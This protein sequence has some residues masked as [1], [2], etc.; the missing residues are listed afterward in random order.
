MQ[1]EVKTVKKVGVG[2]YEDEINN[3]IKPMAG[4]GWTVQQILGS[5]DQGVIILFAKEK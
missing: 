4:D 5:P 1:Y 3:I 2:K